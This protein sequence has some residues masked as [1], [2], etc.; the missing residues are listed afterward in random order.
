MKNQQS[1]KQFV[2]KMLIILCKSN[3]KKQIK[4]LQKSLTLSHFLH[5]IK[6]M[7]NRYAI[8]CLPLMID[9]WLS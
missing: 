8:F 2:D 4:K 3:C 1:Y 6:M 9:N 5:I 7:F